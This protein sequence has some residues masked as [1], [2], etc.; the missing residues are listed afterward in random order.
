MASIVHKR[1]MLK[2]LP[3]QQQCSHVEPFLRNW[4]GAPSLRLICAGDGWTLRMVQAT[5][6]E[7]QARVRCRTSHG[8]PRRWL[9]WSRW[10][11]ALARVCRLPSVSTCSGSAFAHDCLGLTALVPRIGRSRCEVGRSGRVVSV[12]GDARDN[13]FTQRR[14]APL[15]PHDRARSPAPGGRCTGPL[16]TAAVQARIEHGA[17]SP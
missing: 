9:S 7:R 10:P 5:E 11:P 17:P 4:S 1:T 8:A 13:K 14:P 6:D 3:V 16:L 2:S 12:R 15:L